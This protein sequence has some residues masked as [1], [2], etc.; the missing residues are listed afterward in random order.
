MPVVADGTTVEIDALG[1][2][3]SMP[4]EH[5]AQ[6]ATVSAGHRLDRRLQ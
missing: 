1:I 3:P 5:P 4:G 2:A 6:P